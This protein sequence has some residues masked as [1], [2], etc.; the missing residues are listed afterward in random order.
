[1][2][3]ILEGS[4]RRTTEDGRQFVCGPGHPLGNLESQCDAPRWH[5]AVA[6]TAVTGLR[7]DVDVFLHTPEQ[8][9]EMAVDFVAGMASALITRRA[10]LRNEIALPVVA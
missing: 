7:T 5:E 4:V 3:V 6:E 2:Y 8:H 1:M 10:E 9:S